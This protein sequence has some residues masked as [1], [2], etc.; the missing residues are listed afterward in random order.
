MDKKYWF[1]NVQFDDIA[2]YSLLVHCGATNGKEAISMAA[3]AKLFNEDSDANLAS[4]EEA[5][6]DTIKHFTDW[7][8]VQ[9][10]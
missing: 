3:D 2:G 6:D 9:E 1:I 8:L 7:K 5:D 4:C 10:L